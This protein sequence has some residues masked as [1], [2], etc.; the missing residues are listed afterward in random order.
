[1]SIKLMSQVWG[2]NLGTGDTGRSRKLVLM[3]LADHAN[4]E[5]YCYPSAEYV[6]WKTDYSERQIKRILDELEAEHLIRIEKE[7]TPTT[8]R[9]YQL[10]LE[11]AQSK[12]PYERKP[13]GR[14]DI[15]N[16]KPAQGVTSNVARGDIELLRGDIQRARDDIAVSTEPSLEPSIKPPQQPNAAVVVQETEKEKEAEDKVALAFR[17]YQRVVSFG[18][19]PTMAD[20]IREAVRD[21]PIQC[22]KY[23][24]DQAEA[25]N[26]KKWNYVSGV[27]DKLRANGWQMDAKK[28]GSGPPV[29]QPKRYAESWV[30]MQC[31]GPGESLSVCFERLKKIGKVE[32][33]AVMWNP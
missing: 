2:L 33:D 18:F 12:K 13:S 19:S 7:F 1:M 9:V 8:P 21:V 15:Y 3:A 10:T 11:N 5:G 20:K 22:V 25:N 32:P 17:E 6:G 23:A 14:G 16:S 29:K 28:N 26:V 4:D 24:F 27:L 31:N 30:R